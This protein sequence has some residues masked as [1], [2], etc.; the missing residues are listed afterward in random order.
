MLTQINRENGDIVSI[1]N[2]PNI[3]TDVQIYRFILE[4]W[5]RWEKSKSLV[6]TS[7]KPN[8]DTHE[9]NSILIATAAV[10]HITKRYK[11]EKQCTERTEKIIEVSY[12]YGTEDKQALEDFI[13][14]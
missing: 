7:W 12:Y 10:R 6:N 4:Q 13:G 5:G 14:S 2:R 3:K 9:T 8:W 11:V 1:V